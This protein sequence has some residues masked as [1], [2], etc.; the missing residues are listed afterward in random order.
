MKSNKIKAL[1]VCLATLVFLLMAVA[2][3]SSESSSSSNNTT[4][5]KA[6]TTS[7]QQYIQSTSAED[8]SDETSASPES[9]TVKLYFDIDFVPNLVFSTYDIEVYVDDDKIG[10]IP[11]GEHFT[12]LMDI[13][14]GKHTVKFYKDSDNDVSSSKN[15][16]ISNDC[17]FKCSLHS[18][19]SDISIDDYKLEEDVTGASLTMIDVVGNTLDVAR[20]N[21]K[22]VGFVN[23]KSESDNGKIIMLDSNWTVISQNVE[24]GTVADKNIEII[25]TCH[26]EEYS[27]TSAEAET[28]APTT[29]VETSVTSKSVSYSTNDKNSVKDGN[30]GLYSYKNLNGTY[31][32]YYV[33][34]FDN[35]YVYN[36]SEGN[37]S[38]TGDRVKIVS[39][40]LNSVV[41]ITYHDVDGS[42]WSYGLHFKWQRQPDHLVLQ[43]E[44]GAE[45][46]FATTNLKNALSILS[47]K[48]VTDY[49][50]VTT[51]PVSKNELPT[52]QSGVDPNTLITVTN[53]A[54]SPFDGEWTTYLYNGTP[55]EEYAK[56]N[57]ISLNGCVVNMVISGKEIVFQSS[58]NI[59]KDKI[60]NISN[61][62]FTTSDGTEY[63]YDSTNDTITYGYNFQE[64]GIELEFVMKRGLHEF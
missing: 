28:I 50:D 7:V 34:D 19:A 11:H 3:S 10:T 21:L 41:V 31:D 54:T 61:T 8:N 23:I 45:Y 20:K 60:I 42:S 56:Q 27:S 33:I 43:D 48:E 51:F 12:Y 46:D 24:V 53:D 52:M 59:S 36:F 13:Q 16:D 18:Y 22:D 49:S 9:D 38:S 55:V 40:D 29:S 39:G 15:V 6:T 25:L 1:G 26:K 35:G 47:K 58:D 62:S 4:T 14:K 17:T 44:Y 30:K 64:Y 2:S 57:D 37:S 63:K 32:N 5:T